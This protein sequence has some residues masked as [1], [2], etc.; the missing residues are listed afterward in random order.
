MQLWKILPVTCYCTAYL[1]ITIRPQP[2]PMETVLTLPS[3]G[4]CQRVSFFPSY[5]NP[6]TIPSSNFPVPTGH[7]FLSPCV[8]SQPKLWPFPNCNFWLCLLD[9]YSVISVPAVGSLVSSPFATMNPFALP[10]CNSQGYGSSPLI[11][12]GK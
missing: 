1:V 10:T 8:C 2:S 9:S 12:A 11:G 7:A 5:H 3:S 6:S 4:C